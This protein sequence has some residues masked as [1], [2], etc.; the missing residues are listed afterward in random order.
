M[1]NCLNDERITKFSKGNITFEQNIDFNDLKNL[2]K[3]MN[4]KELEL[5]FKNHF[6]NNIK[7]S[8]EN[9]IKTFYTYYLSL[10]IQEGILGV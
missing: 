4:E 1:K 7:R 10:G 5:E 6:E 2:H 8:K 9:P 3:K